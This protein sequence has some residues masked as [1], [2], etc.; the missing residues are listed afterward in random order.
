MNENM[1]FPKTEIL[2]T[3]SLTSL[4]CTC[5]ANTLSVRGSTVDISIKNGYSRAEG[6][7]GLSTAG[8]LWVVTCRLATR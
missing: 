6:F 3:I 2:Q 5:I 4:H 8:V 1:Y 7:R